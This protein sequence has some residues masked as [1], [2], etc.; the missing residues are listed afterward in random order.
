MTRGLTL[1]LLYLRSRVMTDRQSTPSES[2]DELQ[3]GDE[4]VEFAQLL[5][6]CLDVEIERHVLAYRTAMNA[7]TLD[8]ARECLG[9]ARALREFEHVVVQL[10]QHAGLAIRD[11][12][13]TSPHD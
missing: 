6:D 8:H 9:A 4:V 1:R 7:A 5:L 2:E 3:D 10:V 11:E 12:E 13:P